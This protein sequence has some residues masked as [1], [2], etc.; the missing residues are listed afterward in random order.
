M[1][2]LSILA[3]DQTEMKA[4]DEQH[5]DKGQEKGQKSVDHASPGMEPK[6]S[7]KLDAGGKKHTKF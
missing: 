3:K 2:S 4:N 7:L 5:A 6:G 1:F